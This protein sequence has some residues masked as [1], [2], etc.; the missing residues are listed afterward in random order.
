MKFSEMP[1]TRVEISELEKAY[2]DL[3]ERAKAAKSGE[4]LFAVQH[5]YQ[6]RNFTADESHDP[7]A[8]K[9]R[10]RRHHHIDDIVPRDYVEVCIDGFHT[11]VGGYDSWGS[12]PETFRT[13]WSHEDF[14][15]S[16]YIIPE[17]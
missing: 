5:D 16:F 14:S 11:G 17:D 3:I 13:G 2:Q 4:E 12:R 7:A 9:D 6:W 1:Y 15:F 10:L 8:A